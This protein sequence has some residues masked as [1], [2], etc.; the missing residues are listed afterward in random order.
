[1]Q[2]RKKW[3]GEQGLQLKGRSLADQ[4]FYLEMLS[5]REEVHAIEIAIASCASPSERGSIKPDEMN[6]HLFWASFDTG[7][8]T[9]SKS[10]STVSES[11]QW[12]NKMEVAFTAGKFRKGMENPGKG[13]A[14]AASAS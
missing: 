1:M 12:I 13:A 14:A 3:L 11:C 8:E 5:C 9:V 10:F 6:K 4:K 7:N 2:D